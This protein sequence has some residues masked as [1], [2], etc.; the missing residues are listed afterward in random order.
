MYPQLVA[1]IA[2]NSFCSSYAGVDDGSEDM[3]LMLFDLTSR[4]NHGCRP[5]VAQ[6]L[7]RSEQGVSHIQLVAARAIDVGDELNISYL[8]GGQNERFLVVERQRFLFRAWGFQCACERCSE[9]LVAVA[10]DA[11][12]NCTGVDLD[13]EDP[14]E[15]MYR[16]LLEQG[17]LEE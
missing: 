15:V 10:D 11:F 17:V 7:D 8:Y 13:A 3:G 4:M 2:V 1:V 16:Q 5:N 9:E 14:D 6:T 12:A